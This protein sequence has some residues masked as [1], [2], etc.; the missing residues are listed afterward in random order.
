MLK[1]VFWRVVLVILYVMFVSLLMTYQHM[2]KNYH[3]KMW[4]Q[5]ALFLVFFVSHI[6]LLV[7]FVMID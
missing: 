2:H 1:W 6:Y 5:R 7:R 4:F 3:K